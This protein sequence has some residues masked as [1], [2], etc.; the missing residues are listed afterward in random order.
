MAYTTEFHIHWIYQ[1]YLFPVF[2]KCCGYGNRP[3][4]CVSLCIY[5][6]K[7][8]RKLSYVYWVMHSMLNLYYG[9]DRWCC[10]FVVFDCGLVLNKSIHY[11]SELLSIAQSLSLRWFVGVLRPSSSLRFVNNV[12]WSSVIFDCSTNSRLNIYVMMASCTA[13]HNV[14]MTLMRLSVGLVNN[15][16]PS[17]T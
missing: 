4:R 10:Q 7:V 13:D 11:C 9:N 2:E 14:D 8:Y 12:V 5:F 15:S 16:H 6:R 1:N 17:I 3:A